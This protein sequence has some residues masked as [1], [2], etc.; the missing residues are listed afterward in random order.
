MPADHHEYVP[1]GSTKTFALI[2]GINKYQWVPNKYLQGAIRDTDNFKSYLLEY[3]C[4]PEANVF[5]L[6]NE[7]AT[8]SAII[9]K[10]R[11]LERNPRIIPG[12]AAII[13]YFAGG[14]MGL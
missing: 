9:Q 13:I 14:G 7:Q 6:R 2:I 1:G 11:N 12:K 8:R 5:N 3:Q 4:V 10:F